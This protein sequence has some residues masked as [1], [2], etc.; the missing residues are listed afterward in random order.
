MMKKFYFL[1]VP[2]LFLSCTTIN[3]EM[4]L[5][6]DIKKLDEIKIAVLPFT[7][8]PGFP[9]SGI[10]VA[11]ALTNEMMKIDE[12]VMVE[13]SQMNQVINEINIGQA[14]LTNKEYYTIGNMM[15]IDYLVV[16]SVSEYSYTRKMA[17]LPK[18]K[19][20]FNLRIINLHQNTLSGSGRYDMESGKHAWIGCCLLSYYY[21]PIALLSDKNI[22]TDVTRAVKD[23]IRLI[24][25]QLY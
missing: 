15:N 14:G 19:L 20:V 11:D 24:D 5:K 9:G 7:D 3:K 23:I 21:I 16:G 1:A 18:T 10:S 13:R 2:I 4:I 6:R 25:K 8:A 22:N 17:I 12:F